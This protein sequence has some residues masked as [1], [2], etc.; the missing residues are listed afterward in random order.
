MYEDLDDLFAPTPKEEHRVEVAQRVRRIRLRRKLAMA[1][2][3]VVVVAAGGTLSALGGGV[4]TRH[5]T[6]STPFPKSLPSTSTTIKVLPQGPAPEPAPCPSDSET[7]SMATGTYCGPV[8]HAGNGLGPNGECDGQETV[9]PC[10]A[11]AV[12]GT[13]YAYTQ[14]QDC[15]GNPIHFDARFW[16]PTLEPPANL[17]D[18]Y[19][20][21]ALEPNGQ[22]EAISPT[23]SIGFIPDTGQVPVSTCKTG[24]V[25]PAPSAGG[26]ATMP[27][28]TTPPA[29]TSS[30]PPNMNLETVSATQLGYGG[31]TVRTPSGAIAP[32]IPS[33]TAE[34]TVRKGFPGTVHDVE[35]VDLSDIDHI[36]VIN[37]Q[38]Y[39]VE[40][41]PGTSLAASYFVAFVSADDGS[42]IDTVGGS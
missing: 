6:A 30:G 33:S 3:I 37:Q 11:G 29:S 23:E 24:S 8:P 41:T 10:G 20:W 12:V 27:T 2:F 25:S 18:S 36:P 15:A 16:Y 1:G 26:S 38:V 7:P 42:V 35:L 14:P 28:A 4:G 22:L 40:M 13:Y 17:P 5:K 19:V 39:A 31:I 34:A 21:M 9:P 32:V